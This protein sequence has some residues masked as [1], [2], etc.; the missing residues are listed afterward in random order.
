MLFTKT[1]CRAGSLV[2]IVPTG[3]LVTLHYDVHGGLSSIT[4]GFDGTDELSDVFFDQVSKSGVVPCVINARGGTTKIWGVFHSDLFTNPSAALP[5]GEY[6][7]IIEDISKGGC[8]KYHFYIGNV[9]S[10]AA[11]IINP[12]ALNT[13]A[14]TNKFTPLPTWLVPMDADDS[15]LKTYIQTTRNFPFTY[16]LISGF[17]VY[18]DV[19]NPYYQP[20]L[21]RECL[22]TKVR[23][24]VDECGYVKYEVTYA[25]GDTDYTMVI[26]YSDAVRFNIQKG[27]Q[28]IFANDTVVWSDS[29]NSITPK[30]PLERTI[31]CKSC[32]KLLNVPMS[33][34]MTCT[35]PHCTSVLYPRITRFCNVLGLECLTKTTVDK[36][37]HSGNLTTLSDLLLLPTYQ[38]L[39]INKPLC[40]IIFA[41]IS[42]DVGLD[43]QWLFKLCSTCN[44][45]YK[46]IKY[47][48]DNPNKMYTELSFA[49][50]RRLVQ[51]LS[52]P[53]N[54]IELDTIVNSEQVDTSISLR[55]IK[56]DGPPI[57]RDK[58]IYITGVFRHGTTEDIIG[59]LS[60]YGA[61]V[62]T[63]FDQFVQCVLIGDIK[64]GIDGNAIQSANAFGITILEE[65]TFFN[66]YDIDSDLEKYLA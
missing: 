43:K 51:W 32:G 44:N 4:T 26:H 24:I 62:V 7:R 18:Q 38:R 46:T 52:D 36:H 5:I 28:I 10:G 60:S 25:D 42:G 55:T 57:F 29:I 39:T 61:T 58:T 65:S 27:T 35:D 14:R 56:F 47:Y 6:N 11:P 45:N 34:P 17:I 48:L 59:I 9:Q 37:I 3:L 1:F 53:Q 50:P 31:A 2:Y 15:I 8:S 30:R 21:L 19:G 40:D 33:G 63:E 13:W 23:T 66:R 54:L 41:T 49:V 16:P 22:V 12:T 20:T 64:D